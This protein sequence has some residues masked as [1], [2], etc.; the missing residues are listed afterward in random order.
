[1]QVDD[2]FNQIKEEYYNLVEKNESYKLKRWE[3]KDL[4][5]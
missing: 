2:Y 5:K 3:K 1:M 4:K